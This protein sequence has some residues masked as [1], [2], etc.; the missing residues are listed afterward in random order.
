MQIKMKRYYNTTFD[1]PL[2][3][4]IVKVK[5]LIFHV[6]RNILIECTLYMSIAICKI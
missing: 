1:S 3:P 5:Q 2:Q 4:C 6:Q